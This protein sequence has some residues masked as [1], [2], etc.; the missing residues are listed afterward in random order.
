MTF[1]V[2]PV[3]DTITSSGYSNTINPWPIIGVLVAVW[4]VMLVSILIM[5]KFLHKHHLRHCDDAVA[6]LPLMKMICFFC[7]LMFIFSKKTQD[8]IRESRAEKTMEEERLKKQQLEEKRKA[9]M[10]GLRDI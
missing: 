2:A 8:K 6:F 7:F 4:A 10:R 1:L 9:R 3:A 5:N